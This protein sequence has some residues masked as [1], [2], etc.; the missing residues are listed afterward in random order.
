MESSLDSEPRLRCS[1]CE[2]VMIRLGLLV[3]T[4]NCGRLEYRRSSHGIRCE[5]FRV[6]LLR[7]AFAD[8]LVYDSLVETCSSVR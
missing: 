8:L 2:D 7:A 4:V 3:L 5:F 6:T 1:W